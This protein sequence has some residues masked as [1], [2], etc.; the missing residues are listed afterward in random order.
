MGGTTEDSVTAPGRR[1]HLANWVHCPKTS[2]YFFVGFST[3]PEY[4]RPESSSSESVV[5][6]NKSKHTLQNKYFLFSRHWA[7]FLLGTQEL[8]IAFGYYGPSWQHFITEIRGLPSWL[9]WLIW[10]P[11]ANSD[12]TLQWRQGWVCLQPRGSSGIPSSDHMSSD[13]CWWKSK[14]VQHRQGCES[15]RPFRTVNLYHPTY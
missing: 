9:G 15:L 12:A 6:H 14:A 1:H 8:E 10:W 7:P 3:Q 2:C 13:K 4:L 5:S 11:R